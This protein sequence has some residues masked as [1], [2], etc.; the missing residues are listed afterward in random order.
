MNKNK[1]RKERSQLIDLIQVC[2]EYK[3]KAVKQSKNNMLK[4]RPL[5]HWTGY[6][7]EEIRLYEQRIKDIDRKINK[8]QRQSKFT[9]L[10]ITLILLTTGLF[11][12][13]N[14][15]GII[16][17]LAVTNVT[18][19]ATTAN[20]TVANV[21]PNAS[22]VILNSSSLTNFTDENL[23]C[24]AN[25]TDPQNLD[26]VYANYKWYK[27]K[28]VQT[29]LSGQSSSFTQG[30]L[31]LVA[32]L[33]PGNTSRNDNWTCK[34]TPFDGTDNETPIINSCSYSNISC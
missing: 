26:D 21:A 23:T 20:V 17:G 24:W 22:L 31:S 3:Q 1:K 2:E 12:F 32:T 33:G 4:G 14:L 11:M 5:E 27:N 30:V 25:I 28:V 16:T 8:T 19:A 7:E 13:T 34:V 15:E 9:F 10:F 29:S 18:S 6:Y